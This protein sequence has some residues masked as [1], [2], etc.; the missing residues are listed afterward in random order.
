MNFNKKRLDNMERCYAAGHVTIDGE[1]HALMASEQVDGMCCAYSGPGLSRREVVW[2]RAGGTMAIVE[3]PGSNGQ[4]LG[5]QNFFPGFQSE[6]AKVVWAKRDGKAGW[7][8]Q[9]FL[10]L[11]FVHRFDILP[12]GEINFFVA[13]TLCGSKKDREDW[14]DPGKIYAGILP[15]SP[16]Q[17]MELTPILAGLTKNH[18]YWR[19]CRNGIPCGYFCADSGIYRISPPAAPGCGWDIERLL[20]AQVSDAAVYDLNG[21][22]EDELITIEPFHGSCI[23]IYGRTPEGYSP[24]YAYPGEHKFAHALWAGK[25][26]GRPAAIIGLRRMD[27]ELAMIRY[28]PTEGVYQATVIESGMGPS[29]VDV[30]PGIDSDI[31]LCSNNLANEA[32][33]FFVTD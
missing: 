15:S 7:T 31:I 21:D 4:F 25:L 6:Q 2:E 12:V 30:I 17:K 33:A 5:V 20:N 14:S 1:V 29:N 3:I 16:G 8:V 26:R 28:Y 19:G 9:D 24:V 22:G 32:A 23:R 11:P 13:A 27:A 18:G 10:S